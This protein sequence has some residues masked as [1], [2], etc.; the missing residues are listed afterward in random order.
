MAVQFVSRY[1][2]WPL[3]LMPC[4]TT[5]PSS[6]ALRGGDTTCPTRCPT[7]CPTS[8]CLTWR[9]VR[10]GTRA[11]CFTASK[12][13]CQLHPIHFR[14]NCLKSFGCISQ[15]LFT[16]SKFSAGHGA[17]STKMTRLAWRPASETFV[18]I[19]VDVSS[20]G[21]PWL[22]TWSRTNWRLR[23][24]SIQHPLFFVHSAWTCIPSLGCSCWETTSTSA[25]CL[26]ASIY[27][28]LYKLW[29]KDSHWSSGADEAA[30][31][32]HTIRIRN[33]IP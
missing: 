30:A 4:P 27:C 24:F 31:R 32:V 3:N 10:G 17:D 1:Q 33:P 19:I 11:P 16:W 22:G 29:E 6:C 15:P 14:G 9:P 13:C 26:A 23:L 20:S 18:A 5:S 8:G 7:S 25:S 28:R 12:R 21:G 2:A